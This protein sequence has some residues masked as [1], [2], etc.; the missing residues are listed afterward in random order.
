MVIYVLYDLICFKL[1]V[2]IYLC[3]YIYGYIRQL[4]VGINVIFIVRLA[5][6]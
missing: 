6:I 5:C 3:V 1:A 2:Y 4:G